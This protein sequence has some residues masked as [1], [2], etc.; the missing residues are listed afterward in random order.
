M[1][2]TA[3]TLKNAKILRLTQLSVLVALLLIFGFTNIGYIKIGVIEITLNIIPV[4]VGAI[5]LGPS[6]GAVCG[7]V[8]GLTSFW[9]AASGTSAFGMMLFQHSPLYTFILC[10]IPRLLEGLL[11]AL[12]FKALMKGCKNNS[13]P[14]AV[15]SLACPLLNTLM[16]VGSFILLFMKTDIFTNL[17]TQSAATNI[18]AFFV[19]FVGLNGLVEAIAGFI[20]ATAV[21][22]ALLTANKRLKL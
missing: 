4:A 22:K 16:F 6:A 14:C 21:S 1:K 17:Y 8:F 7:A 3:K 20:I 12:I 18:G 5:V 10:F 15:A 19:W 13:L 2:K 11:T 9:Q